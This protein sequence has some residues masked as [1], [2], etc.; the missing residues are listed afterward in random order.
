[1]WSLLF[2][3]SRSCYSRRT[4]RRPD[5]RRWFK[6]AAVPRVTTRSPSSH[7]CSQSSSLA[8][9]LSFPIRCMWCARRLSRFRCRDRCVA[10]FISCTTSSAALAAGKKLKVPRRSSWRRRAQRALCACCSLITYR[11]C[12][13]TLHTTCSECFRWELRNDVFWKYK[14]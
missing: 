6:R 10:A 2:W 5:F 7:L 12:C 9:R 11:L 8:S 1:M 4:H 14:V 13:S 3:C